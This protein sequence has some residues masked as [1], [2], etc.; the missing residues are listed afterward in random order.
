MRRLDIGLETA[1][2][3]EVGEFLADAIPRAGDIAQ[4]APRG[5]AGFE[6]LV[7]RGEGNGI[8]LGHD[9][10]RVRDLDFSAALVQ[11]TH[12]HGDALQHIDWLEPGNHAGDAVLL[13]QEAVR[14]STD[15]GAHVTREDKRVELER[16]I[17]YE[18]LQRTGHV[19]VRREHGEVGKSHGLRAL[20]RHSHKRSRRLEADAHKDDLPLGMRLRKGERVEGR[21]DDLDRAAR[22]LLRKQTRSGPGDARHVAEG[23]DGDVRNSRKRDHRVD[24]A[25]ARDANGTPRARRQ[26]K[27]FRHQIADSIAC[28]CHGMRAAHLHERRVLGRKAVDGLDEAARELRVFKRREIDVGGILQDTHTATSSSCLTSSM[29]SFA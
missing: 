12:E 7:D 29:V 22:G 28:D 21:I 11:L 26:A 23:G 13:R 3:V 25:V 17:A 10:A 8:P 6:D 4:A 2:R 1:N 20:D 24:V 15:D 27:S 9:A 19:L 14:L 18:Q 5:R 16:G